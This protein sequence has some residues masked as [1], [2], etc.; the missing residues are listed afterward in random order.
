MSLNFS[1]RRQFLKAS[2]LLAIATLLAP[3]MAVLPVKSVSN[4]QDNLQPQNHLNGRSDIRSVDFDS[5]NV[6]LSA[7]QK[8]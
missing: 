8:Y 6:V 4:A 1:S 5:H 3:A 7:W 2:S